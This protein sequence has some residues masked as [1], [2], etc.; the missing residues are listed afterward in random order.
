MAGLIWLRGAEGTFSRQASANIFAGKRNTGF[1]P[2]VAGRTGNGIT[3][4]HPDSESNV[5][6]VRTEL[7]RL[8]EL[9]HV[10]LID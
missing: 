1:A 3:M 9:M 2:S 6:L 10:I 4:Y 7:I 5:C 8:D